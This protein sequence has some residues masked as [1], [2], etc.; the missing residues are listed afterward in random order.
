MSSLALP[1]IHHQEIRIPGSEPRHRILAGFSPQTGEAWTTRACSVISND[2][3]EAKAKEA[4]IRSEA[5]D[6]APMV[7]DGDLVTF[8]GIPYQVKING[9]RYS[10]PVAFIREEKGEQP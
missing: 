1:L 10:D 6:V 8:D 9:I 5:F 7:H 2:S 3:P 4:S